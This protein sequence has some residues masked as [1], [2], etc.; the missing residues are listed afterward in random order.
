M[1]L[2][3]DTEIEITLRIQYHD[4]GQ[5]FGALRA[6]VIGLQH[7]QHARPRHA[8]DERHEDDREREARQDQ[9]EVLVPEGRE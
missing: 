1:P 4:A 7:L 3:D 8:R 6:Y 2:R 5:A 9:P